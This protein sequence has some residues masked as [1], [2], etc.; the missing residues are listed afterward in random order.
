[1]NAK[2]TSLKLTIPMN[3]MNCFLRIHFYF[4]FS[5]HRV[6][7]HVFVQEVKLTNTRNTPFSID[8]ETFGPSVSWS[9]SETKFV[10]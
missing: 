10:K 8:V 2:N 6:V 5:A 3:I 4:K 1:M 9:G 7:P